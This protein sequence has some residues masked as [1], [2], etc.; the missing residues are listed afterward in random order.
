MP[1]PQAERAGARDREA[2]RP[3]RRRRRADTWRRQASRARSPNHRRSPAR[4]PRCAPGWP[5]PRGPTG[6]PFSRLDPSDPR[7]TRG[8]RAPLPATGKWRR[9]GMGKAAQVAGRREQGSPARESRRPRPP[10]RHAAA[11]STRARR[12]A[13]STPDRRPLCGARI[14]SEGDAV[15]RGARPLGGCKARLGD[16]VELVARRRGAVCHGHGAAQRDEKCGG[17]AHRDQRC[18]H[19]QP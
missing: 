17:E 10:A 18:S 6:G 2:S 3:A 1:L 16:S 13:G 15:S 9:E 19:G 4:E 12:P 14:G 5:P 7:E 11:A 8:G